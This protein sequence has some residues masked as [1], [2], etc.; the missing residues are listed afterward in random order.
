M[1]KYL[2][3]FSV[4][5]LTILTANLL[6][7]A[8]G[9]YMISYKNS[10]KPLIFTLI[11]MAIIVVVFYPLFMK[12]EV[13]VTDFSVKVIRSGKSLAGKY[14][15]LLLTFITAMLV[16]VYFYAKM[17]YHLDILR[18]LLHGNIGGYL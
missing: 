10:F 6:T 5:T 7:T 3:R 17:W 12:L 1:Y 11:G 2:F 9:S 4:T 16:L 14:L 15:G 18:V 8:I 13:W